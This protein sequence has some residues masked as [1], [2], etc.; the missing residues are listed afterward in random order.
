MIPVGS[1]QALLETTMDQL[2]TL[3]VV[4]EV[5]TALGAARLLGREQSSVQKQLDTL[6]RN[7]Y[8]LCGEELVLKQGRGKDVLFTSTGTAV[9]ELAR[10]TLANWLDGIRESRRRLGGSLVVGTTRYTLGYLTH[11]VELVAEEFRRRGVELRIEH[12]RTRDLLGKLRT[13]ETD[14]VCG[15]VMTTPGSDPALDDFEVMEWRRSGIA[16]LTNLPIARLPG[17]SI[18]NGELRGLP[19]VVSGSGLMADFLRGWFGAEFRGKLNIVA[20][21]DAVNYG[22]E[23]LG[24]GLLAGCMLITQGIAEAAL[25]GRMPGAKGLRVIEVVHQSGPELEVLVGAF[26]RRGERRCRAD[27]HPLN[28]LWAALTGQNE[29]W[30]AA[31]EPGA[32][33]GYGPGRPTL[34]TAMPPDPPDTRR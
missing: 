24:S 27:D 14:L 12:T 19:L 13:K 6:N 20:E 8:R 30:H 15:S 3:I 32:V 23:L 29:R 17:P 18:G 7:F 34:P 31:E 1:P 4:H 26:A 16:V 5:G 25:D 11:G 10:A 28:L 9:V 21:I 2:R 33:P 22:L